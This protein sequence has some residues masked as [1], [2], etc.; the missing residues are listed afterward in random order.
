ME[1]KFLLKC[2]S[3]LKKYFDGEKLDNLNNLLEKK[4]PE[5]K[6]IL[7]KAPFTNRKH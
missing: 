1:I 7:K 5:Q 3:N 4:W 2:M 6:A